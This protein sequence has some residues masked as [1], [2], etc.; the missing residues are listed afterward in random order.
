M[1][2]QKDEKIPVRH[3]RP[4]VGVVEAYADGVTHVTDGKRQHL[5]ISKLAW[6]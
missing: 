6:R 4:F 2:L 1:I 5:D 3:R